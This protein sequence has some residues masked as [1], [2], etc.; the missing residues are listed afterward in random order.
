ANSA[1]IKGSDQSFE[2]FNT[3]GNDSL[4]PERSTEWE[5]GFDSK[6]F[7]NRIQFDVTY[8]SRL[9]HDALI[10]AIVAPSAGTGATT[11]QQNLGSTKNAGWELTVGGQLID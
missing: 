1:S 9:T 3:I 11:Q 10:A 7:G 4:K 2:T 8:F 5:T 6:L